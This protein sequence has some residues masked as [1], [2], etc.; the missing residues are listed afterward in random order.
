MS[1]KRLFF[2]RRDLGLQIL[3]LYLLFVGFVALAAYK[4]QDLASQRLEAD[5]Q[6]ADLSLARAI[7]QET[8]TVMDG[9]LQTVNQLATYPAVIEADI[10]GMGDIFTILL[11]AR[12]DV[13]LVYRLD[14]QGIMLYHYPEGPGST[15]GDDF[16][17][18]DYFQSALTTH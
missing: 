5:V 16:S 8:N 14:A 9:A 13:N 12:T 6:A 7:A 3:A 10:D 17:F 4:F 1:S 18:R 11:S 2:L 15:V